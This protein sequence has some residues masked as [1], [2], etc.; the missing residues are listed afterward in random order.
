[1]QTSKSPAKMAESPPAQP[2]AENP[3]PRVYDCTGCRYVDTHG[4]VC[5]VCMRKILDK[6]AERKASLLAACFEGR[7]CIT[8]LRGRRAVL[9]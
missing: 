9:V 8:L 4:L 7:G 2:E 1:M 3:V 5:D 6:Q